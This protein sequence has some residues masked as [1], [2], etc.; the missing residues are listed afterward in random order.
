MD[1]H[2]EP[3]KPWWREPMVWLVAGLPLTAVV[4]GIAT[5]LIAIDQQDSLVDAHVHKEGLMFV[6]KDAQAAFSA[7]ARLDAAGNL[8]VRLD[9]TFPSLPPVLSANFVQPGG[10]TRAIT[11]RQVPGDVP[12][13]PAYLAQ[14]PNMGKGGGHLILHPEDRSW[15]LSGELQVPNPEEVQLV[16][17]VPHSSTHP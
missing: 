12:G 17:E 16:A 8:S 10:E 2:A 1:R 5:V 14:L 9:G 3:K 6:A 15:Q 13:N 11:L 7:R 4:A